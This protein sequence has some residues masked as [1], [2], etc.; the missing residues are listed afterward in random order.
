M[1]NY[2]YSLDIGKE[3]EKE[4]EQKPLKELLKESEE[5]EK[6]KRE[7]TKIETDIKE[8]EEIHISI[9]NISDKLKNI[10]KKNETNNEVNNIENKESILTYLSKH[11]FMIALILLFIIGLFFWNNNNSNIINEPN[12]ELKTIIVDNTTTNFDN[13]ENNNS[14][15][16]KETL[17]QGLI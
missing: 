7:A 17:I 12:L 16:L 2:S 13:P 8:K 14:T 3:L 6:N 4:L 15:Q 5:T 10:N 11:K 9:N 1:K